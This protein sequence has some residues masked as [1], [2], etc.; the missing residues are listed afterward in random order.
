MTTVKVKIADKC[1]RIIEIVTDGGGGCLFVDG[2]A[3]ADLEQTVEK[4][5]LHNSQ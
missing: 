5:E 3:I 2:K 1:E 4:T